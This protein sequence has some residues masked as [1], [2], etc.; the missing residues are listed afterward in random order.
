MFSFHI[1]SEPWSPYTHETSKVFYLKKDGDYTFSVRSKDNFGNVEPNPPTYIFTLDTISPILELDPLP[2]TTT[3]NQI[4]INGKSEFGCKLLI[5]GIQQQI[6]ANGS[7]FRV[8]ELKLGINNIHISSTDQTGNVS[9]IEYSITRETFTPVLIQLQIG[10]LNATVKNN[11]VL[12]D[13]APFTENGRTMVPLRF[14]AE[15]FGAKVDWLEI[16]QKITISLSVPYSR[17]IELWLDKKTVTVDGKEREIDVAPFTIPPGRSVVPL[18]FIAESFGAKVDWFPN[19]QSIEILFPK[20]TN[21]L[22]AYYLQSWIQNHFQNVL[23]LF[24]GK[25]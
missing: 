16:E 1:N 24:D 2:S 3:N 18:R 19:T 10:N 5:N 4:T 21:S 25:D 13:C 11:P 20:N 12:L 22:R 14:I 7:F 17:K 6:E 9:A 23:H 8:M 15:S